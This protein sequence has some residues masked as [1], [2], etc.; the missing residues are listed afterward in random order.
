MLPPLS[1]G[2]MVMLL[3]FC[4]VM[5]ALCS[6]WLRFPLYLTLF[7]FLFVFLSSTFLISLMTKF[8]NT[9]KASEYSFRGLKCDLGFSVV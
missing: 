9:L 1:A 3:F 5:I 7:L 4:S 2:R 8:W 6:F